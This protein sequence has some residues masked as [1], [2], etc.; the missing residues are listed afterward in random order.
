MHPV[1]HLQAL[2]N[3]RGPLLAVEALQLLAHDDLV[4]DR[5][6]VAGGEQGDEGAERRV[7]GQV[8]Q[9][10]RQLVQQLGAAVELQFALAAWEELEAQGEDL[11]GGAGDVG[12][13]GR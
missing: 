1:N 12:L 10:I 8:A 7:G 3:G 2:Q 6:R 11:G 13:A 4:V 5:D 9:H